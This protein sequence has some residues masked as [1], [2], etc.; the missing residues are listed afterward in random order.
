MC[1][2]TS[3]VFIPVDFLIFMEEV[4]VKCWYVSLSRVYDN[5]R[6]I[7]YDNP[8]SD[9]LI[10]IFAKIENFSSRGVL[11]CERIKYY[12]TLTSRP[13]NQN[14]GISALIWLLRETKSVGHIA[15]FLSGNYW[16]CYVSIVLPVN[17]Y[18]IHGYAG[19]KK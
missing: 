10:S 2:K 18:V 12:L 8:K 19:S 15:S 16:W 4:R 14:Y 9:I 1:S 5:I 7:S 13:L 6:L 11:K 17:Q 3:Y